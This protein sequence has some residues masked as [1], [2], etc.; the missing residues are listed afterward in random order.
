MLKAENITKSFKGKVVLDSVSLEVKSGETV[1]LMGAN[2]L[3]K[4]T[5]LS[6]MALSLPPDSGVVRVD[7]L[8]MKEAKKEIAFAPQAVTLFEELSVYENLLAWSGLMGRESK[9]RAEE[10]IEVLGMNDF[11]RKRVDKLSGGQ[12]RRVNLG[13]TLMSDARYILLDEPFA[14]IDSDGEK[15]IKDIILKEKKKDK[16]IIIAEHNTEIINELADRVVN[17]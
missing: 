5:L 17:L 2:G 4:S 13:V 7:D 6:I 1:A 3:G 10:L 11:R 16:G 8:D 9:E 12:R 14:G 15:L